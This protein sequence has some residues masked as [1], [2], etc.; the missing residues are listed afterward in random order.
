MDLDSLKVTEDAVDLP[1]YNPITGERTDI[2]IKVIGQ[3]S[4]EYKQKARALYKRA[5]KK[6]PK[7][8]LAKLNDD[9]DEAFAV[10]L[11]AAHIKGWENMTEKGKALPFSVEAA[12]HVI[13]NYPVIADQVAEFVADRANF[14]KAS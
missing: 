10:K 6:A 3:D 9:D 7:G 13:R 2:T 1:I 4:E 12:E 8:D 14:M 11:R 5:L